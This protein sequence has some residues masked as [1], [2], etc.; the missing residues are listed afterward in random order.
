MGKMTQCYEQ[1][2]NP[3]LP[4]IYTKAH[5]AMYKEHMK[6]YKPLSD[7][8][9]TH[10]EI[11]DLIMDRAANPSAKRG[12]NAILALAEYPKVA[13]AL[14]SDSNKFPKSATG[15]KG[16]ALALEV[17]PEDPHL[18]CVYSRGYG[19]LKD[20][21]ELLKAKK[22]KESADKAHNTGRRA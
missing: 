11:V 17:V 12:L 4:L 15:V 13:Q 2:G 3:Q 14:F 9:M 16:K 21:C 19:H 5:T 7:R 6:I 22:R 8:G 10:P 18:Y 20:V 1:C